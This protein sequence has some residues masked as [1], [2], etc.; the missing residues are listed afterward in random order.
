MIYGMTDAELIAGL[1]N[2]AAVL[3]KEAFTYAADRIEALLAEREKDHANINLKAD[4]ID[5]TINQLAETEAKLSKAIGTLELV[6]MMDVHELIDIETYE[7]CGVH[8]GTCG[9]LAR[10][11]LAELKGEIYDR[12]ATEK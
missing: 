9:R 3:G 4:F 1:R 2:L 12:P 11:T 10:D 6:Q 7:P 5:N 8:L